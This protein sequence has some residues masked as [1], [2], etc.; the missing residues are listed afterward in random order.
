MRSEVNVLHVWMVAFSAFCLLPAALASA[1][2]ADS[3]PSDKAKAPASVTELSVS[4]DPAGHINI[5][6]AVDRPSDVT[7]G[8]I[9]SKGKVV[10]HLASGMLGD[11][12]PAPL[13][14]NATRQKI[15]WD[16]RDDSGREL[17]PGTYRASLGVTLTGRY[18]GVIGHSPY[19]MGSVAGL[20]IAPDGNV[21]I[22]NRDFAKSPNRV[23]LYD[24]SGKYL[25]TIMP[26]DPNY[27]KRRGLD[28]YGPLTNRRVWRSAYP[29]GHIVPRM[30]MEGSVYND[31]R[32]GL[33]QIETDPEGN[34]VLILNGDRTIM[35]V[36]RNGLPMRNSFANGYTA[37]IPWPQKY[38]SIL[39]SH[40]DRRT[41]KLY[42]A[43]GG[44]RD[45][46]DAAQQ[47]PYVQRFLAEDVSPA[48]P[49][50]LPAKHA[51]IVARLN[52]DA[53]ASK[54]FLYEG[55]KK[56]AEPKYHLGV[57]RHKGD[58]ESHFNGPKGIA[59]D[60]EGCVIVADSGNNRIQVFRAD[61]YYLA[62]VSTYRHDGADLPLENVSNLT[63]DSRS[64][65][66]FAMVDRDGGKRVVRLR[67]WR[68][69]KTIATV[70]LATESRQ[71]VVDPKSHTL[72]VANGG[73]QATFTRIGLKAKAFGEAVNFA[74]VNVEA[75]SNPNHLVDDGHGGLL[76]IERRRGFPRKTIR[77]DRDGKSFQA[78]DFLGETKDGSV[79]ADSRGNIYKLTDEAILKYSPSGRPVKFAALEGNRIE[80]DKRNGISPREITVAPNG[81]IYATLVKWE[82]LPEDYEGDLD[83][84][85]HH[86]DGMYYPFPAGL[87][88]VFSPD[89]TCKHKQ[90]VTVT[91]PRGIRVNRAGEVY[92]IEG[93]K[94]CLRSG[95]GMIVKFASAG[96]QIGGKGEMW[97]RHGMSPIQPTH[98][99][100]LSGQID[101]DEAGNLYATHMYGFHIQVY[102]ANGNLITRIGDYGNQD[103]L[104]PASDKPHPAVP[105]Y[106]IRGVAVSDGCMYVSDYGNRR[107]VKIDLGYQS[108]KSVSFE[109]RRAS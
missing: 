51:Q 27:L 64:D 69:P 106:V 42:L 68:E 12:A 66:L 23:Q 5:A 62:T 87:V 52:G 56:L 65:Q 17:P 49:A 77:I 16:G 7:L 39:Y 59:T 94:G 74:G 75:F 41:G 67:S 108:S 48:W 26:F 28:L 55:R 70:D 50:G 10:R 92:L 61:G 32:C 33:E 15:L 100:C 76:V 71:M 96:G 84:V 20:A 103:C 82:P 37:A 19:A 44:V 89:G 29:G 79:A 2:G 25:R 105:L 93:P 58:D 14:A 3:Q 101:L 78:M 1:V 8:V 81:D 9:N 35:K 38:G 45:P 30:G 90:L 72:W 40:L 83:L 95:P 24:S 104:G 102:D 107:I 31:T 63:T 22:A 11:N 85:R 46:W 47:H 6:F 99:G 60:S 73:G 13:K 88:D 86:G 98:C 36:D 18:V 57:M 109:L 97:R 80:L 43:D 4:P 34:L 54:T 91:A 21:V 53:T